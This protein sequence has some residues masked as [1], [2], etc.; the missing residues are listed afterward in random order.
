[1]KTYSDPAK[2]ALAKGDVTSHGA[3]EILG[4][5]PFRVWG[6][7]GVL[8]LGGED[9]QG[10]G[11]AG[12]ITVTGSQM[13]GTEDG[14][15]LALSGVDP[16]TADLSTTNLVRNARATIWRLLFDGAGETLLDAQVFER[17]RVDQLSWKDTPGGEATITTAIE[18][19]ARGLGRKTGRSTADADQRMI[20]GDDGS[21]SRVTQAGEL[22][23]AWGGKP[24]ARVTQALPTTGGAF[25]PYNIDLSGI[26]F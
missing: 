14:I 9:F 5:D 18:T 22:T 7:A 21:L 23:L 4:T 2:A 13:G 17:G 8:P 25:D 16:N 20:D 26:P 15:E 24:P 12:L 10:V 6:G 1:M 3:V 19:A 11:D